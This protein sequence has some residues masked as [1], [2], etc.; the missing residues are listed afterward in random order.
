[1]R[2][3]IHVEGAEGELPPYAP[4]DL[5]AQLRSVLVA[6]GKSGCFVLLLGESAV[7]KTRTLYEAIQATLPDWWLVHPDSAEALCRLADAPS[8]RTVVWLDELQRYLGGRQGLTAGPV[9]ALL[10]AGVVIVAT[11]WPDEHHVR[12]APRF[13]GSVDQYTEER[14]LLDLAEVIDVASQLSA[15]ERDRVHQLATTDKRWRVRLRCSHRCVQ[16]A[17]ALAGEHGVEGVGNLLSRS[18][19]TNVNRATRSPRAIRRFRA[20]RVTQAALGFAVMPRRYPRRVACSTTN[21]TDNRPSSNVSTQ[22]KSVARM[23][24]AWAVRNCLQVG[25][26]R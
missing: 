1:V 18:R 11:M 12:T 17:D 16:D 3:A 9:R 4:R 6:D 24:W 21:N 2:A 26:L 14:Q 13:P 20:C 25:P 15:A 19:I 7:G 23:P 8:A 5:D 22:K 10:Q